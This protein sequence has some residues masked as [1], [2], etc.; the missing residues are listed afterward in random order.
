MKG[1]T[2]DTKRS[3]RG[4]A[5]AL[6]FA[7]SLVPAAAQAQTQVK[8]GWNVF[9]PEQD[10][11][12]GRQSVAQIEQQLPVVRNDRVNDFVNDIGRRLAAQAP[13]PKFPYQFG[14][15]NASDLNAFALPG[16]PIY[17]NRGIIEAARNEG[18]VAGVLAHEIAHIALRHGTA[19]ASKQQATQAGLSILGGLLGG[20]VSGNTAQIVNAVGGFGLNALFLKYSREAERDADIL[21]AQILAKAGYSPQDMVGFFQTLEKQDKRKKASFLQSHPAPAQR[22]ATIEKE[23]RLIG[24]TQ[25]ATV[26]AERLG[27]VQA[28]LRSLGT[29]RSSTEIAQSGARNPRGQRPGRSTSAVQRVEPPS[30]SLRTYT[31]RQRLF[32][33]QVPSNWQVAAEGDESVTFLPQGGA[34]DAGNGRTEI[35]YGLIVNHYEPFGNRRIDLSRVTVEQATDDLLQQIVRTSPHLRMQR[36]SGQAFRVAGGKGLGATLRGTSPVT[37]LAERVTVVTRQL[38]DGHLI[39]MLFVTPDQD[40]QA[41]A[42]VIQ[43][44]VNSFRVDDDGRH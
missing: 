10:V 37:G 3:L 17:I 2:M 31:N 43:A 28:A 24:A 32:Q 30:R 14:V 16:G 6:V 44:A 36:G 19:N 18:E 5:A 39:Y 12:I 40:A 4:R 42:P 41:Y 13:G 15:I 33:L 35:V 9:S 1:E 8:G 27:G 21:G 25:P 11:E 26:R 7:L 23:A 22:V 34:L 20:R 29:A 38:A